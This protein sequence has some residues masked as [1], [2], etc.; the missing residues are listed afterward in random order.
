MCVASFSVLTSEKSFYWIHI[1]HLVWVNMYAQEISFKVFLNQSLFWPKKPLLYYFLTFNNTDRTMLTKF[2]LKIGLG[3]VQFGIQPIPRNEPW[4]RSL[5]L[6]SRKL[7]LF[8]S[9]ET[10]RWN[11]NNINSRPIQNTRNS[12]IIFKYTVIQ[13]WFFHPKAQLVF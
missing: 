5:G 4:F 7:V 12:I 2:V 11:Q 9:S 3:D 1:N 10:E 8:D 6:N 13:I